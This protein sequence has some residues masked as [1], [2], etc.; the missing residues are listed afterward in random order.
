M[1]DLITE[2]LHLCLRQSMSP[3]DIFVIG[4]VL[5]NKGAFL[6]EV[7]I[8]NYSLIPC[9]VLDIFEEFFS[10]NAGQRVSD[11]DIRSA[12]VYL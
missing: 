8:L 10:W 1:K 2:N 3:L 5:R 11:S 7:Q 4:R 9:K 12:F 6:E